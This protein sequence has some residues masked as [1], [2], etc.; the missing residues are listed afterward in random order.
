M[1]RCHK[2]VNAALDMMTRDNRKG[3][4]MDDLAN[5]VLLG[6]CVSVLVGLSDRT[7]EAGRAIILTVRTATSPSIAGSPFSSTLL[8]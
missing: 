6:P 2:S 5:A 8:I 3:E 1:M 7:H 4:T